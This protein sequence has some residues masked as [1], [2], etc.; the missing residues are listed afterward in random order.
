MDT[1]HTDDSL[2]FTPAPVLA[3]RD[4]W[5][6][7]RQR[8]FIAALARHGGIAEA[9]RSVGMTPQTARRLRK[10]VGAEDFARAWDAAV[11]EGR[12]RAFDT[13]LRIGRD[14]DYVPLFRNGRQ[15]GIR[16]RFNNRLLFAACY[17]EPMSRYD[18]R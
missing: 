3:R 17:G 6:A 7:D 16:H 8:A 13:A 14:G 15:I 10:R 1:P 4:G 12:L 9:A 11:E 2:S 18:R 5:T